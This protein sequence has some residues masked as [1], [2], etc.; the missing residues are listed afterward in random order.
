V[1]RVR[2]LLESL[3]SA[4]WSARAAASAGNGAIFA[5]PTCRRRGRHR[6]RNQPSRE[7]LNLTLVRPYPVLDFGL[8]ISMLARRR[9][10]QEDRWL[11]GVAK[12]KQGEALAVF[13]SKGVQIKQW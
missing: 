4:S 6:S 9:C 3:R 5:C 11:T 7:H 12:T 13:A 8:P 2:P 1:T 10:V